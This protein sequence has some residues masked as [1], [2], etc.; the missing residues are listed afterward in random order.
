MRRIVYCSLIITFMIAGNATA[1]NLTSEVAARLD[2]FDRALA[3]LEQADFSG[4][5]STDMDQCDEYHE[6]FFALFESD[7]LLYDNDLFCFARSLNAMVA[8]IKQEDGNWS[9]LEEL[10]PDVGVEEC[11]AFLDEG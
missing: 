8:L 7:R 1:Q 5:F 9:V 2:I 3:C 10:E 11:R 6:A 4:D